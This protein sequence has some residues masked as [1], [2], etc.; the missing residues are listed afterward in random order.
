MKLQLGVAAKFEGKAGTPFSG[1]SLMVHFLL[2]DFEDETVFKDK[3]VRTVAERLGLN[4]SF[5]SSL[6]CGQ[7]DVP[8][9][10]FLERMLF[11]NFVRQQ[12]RVA[13]SQ[14]QER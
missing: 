4:V 11:L 10:L 13:A 1:E 14:S 9:E 3:T 2:P 6:V 7:P 5:G 8:T 12:E